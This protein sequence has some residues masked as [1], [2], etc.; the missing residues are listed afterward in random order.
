MRGSVLLCSC[1]GTLDILNEQNRGPRT[2][3]PKSQIIADSTFAD[4]NKHN[5]TVKVH[6]E[7]Y[8]RL[9]FSTEYN[10]AKFYII[11][12]Y[13]EDNVHKSIKYGVKKY[14]VLK[15]EEVCQ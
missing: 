15:K 7:L 5:T 2:F 3:K 4:N 10:E 1:N 9:D 6:D 13:S 14:N 12:S 8:N 11:K